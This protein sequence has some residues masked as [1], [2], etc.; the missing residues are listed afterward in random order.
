RNVYVT[1]ADPTA[2]VRVDVEETDAPL[3]TP[4]P[5]PGQPAPTAAMPPLKVNGLRSSILLNPDPTSPALV[6]PDLVGNVPDIAELE[7]HEPVVDDPIFFNVNDPRT[8]STALRTPADQNPADQ[9][10]ADQNPAD[11]NITDLN[12]ADQNPADQN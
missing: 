6:G 12:P 10:P 8:R 3:A 2:Q 9:N 4:A 5:V 1:A 11:Q 7:V